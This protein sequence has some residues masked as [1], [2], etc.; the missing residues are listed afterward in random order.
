MKQLTIQD[1]R[2]LNPCYSPNKFLPEDWSGDIMD[3]L[4]LEQVP[5]KDR[6]WVVVRQEFMSDRELKLFGLAC[7]R[8]LKQYA[9]D[10]D[11]KYCNDILEA[12]IYGFAT[13]TELK[14]TLLAAAYATD[15]EAT[16]DAIYCAYAAATYAANYATNAA[17]EQ[18]IR[19]LMH[20]LT[21]GE[22]YEHE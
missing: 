21:T 1:I 8:T 10:S 20:I 2:D 6:I 18:N 22:M 11:I 13:D 12:N 5:A 7:A 9:H 3:I 15:A 4:K 17:Q 19:M 14:A 16:A